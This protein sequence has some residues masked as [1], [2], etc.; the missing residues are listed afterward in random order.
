MTYP[1][2]LDWLFHQLPMYQRIGKAAYKADLEN[3]LALMKHLEQPEEGFKSIHVA[4]T[5]GKGSVSHMLASI[6]QQAGYKTGLYTSPHLVDFRERIR[7]NGQMI[8]EQDVVDFVAH[9]K[10]F[11]EEQQLSFFEMTVGMAFDYFRKE[12][13]DIAIVETGLGGRLDST[14][15][16]KPELSVITNIG[17]D[18]TQFLGTD[19]PS[20]AAEKAGI[21]KPNTPVVIGEADSEIL[22]VFKRK[23]ENE[24]APLYIVDQATPQSLECDLKG[25][26][27]QKNIRTAKQAVELLRENWNVSEE[28]L[29]L[30]LKNVVKNTGL[31]GR[32]QKLHESPLVL[33]DTGHNTEGISQLMQQLKEVNKG[34]LYLV[35]GMVNDKSVDQVLELLPK[36]AQVYACQASIPRAMEA[37]ELAAMM[38]A[39]QL[40][41]QTIA[42]PVAA[43]E[44]ALSKA[45]KEDTVFVGGSTFVVADVLSHLQN[46]PL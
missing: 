42:K 43:L 11:F 35:M 12:K 27:Q 44:M 28:N 29:A 31:Q 7:I 39:K 32:W 1:E 37:D 38:A 26:Y 45:Q 3:T 23:A 34:R 40:Q 4:G 6:F 41:V 24:H 8:P 10:S 13:V 33:C 25:Y 20:I 22:E 14:N 19:R 9:H 18:H 21:I 15:V 2:T 17:L 30:G 36:D 46:H 16:L 5:N